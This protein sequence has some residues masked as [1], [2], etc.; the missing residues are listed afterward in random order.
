MACREF[1][2]PS[3][4]Q[5][6]VATH[7]GFPCSSKKQRTGR[8]VFGNMKFWIA[9]EPLEFMAYFFQKWAIVIC[10]RMKKLVRA[11]TLAWIHNQTRATARS[12]SDLS[13]M[14]KFR[15]GFLA[16]TSD[17]DQLPE[18]PVPIIPART[19]RV[20]PLNP[21]S[22]RSAQ[23][24]QRSGLPQSPSPKIAAVSTCQANVSQ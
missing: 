23:C 24:P 18:E 17:G 1:S 2:Y 7:H 13:R 19:C 11:A 14:V 16:K 6:S 9:V 15:T 21:S 10:F 8:F 3:S 22:R 12:R 4:R 20:L 5:T